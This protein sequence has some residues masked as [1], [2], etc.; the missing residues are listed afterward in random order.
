MND[1]Y[2]NYR[3]DEKREKQ[4]KQRQIIEEELA[5]LN[6]DIKDQQVDLYAEDLA[7]I[8]PDEISAA[9][10]LARRRNL[11][12][13]IPT[14]GQILD[15]WESLK[16]KP[17][18]WKGN[19]G[20]ELQNVR[21]HGYFTIHSL[22]AAYMPERWKYLLQQKLNGEITED[23]WIELE[24]IKKIKVFR[25]QMR[26]NEGVA[27]KISLIRNPDEMVDIADYKH[28]F[29]GIVKSV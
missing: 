5:R 6:P 24:E 25:P 28:L 9:F 15:A 18:D 16:F 12:F 11:K 1:D 17:G 2:G 29:E 7:E 3:K 27:E 13:K 4:Q 20:K 23:E 21:A 10:R 8:P 22:P 14:V 26:L 19:Q